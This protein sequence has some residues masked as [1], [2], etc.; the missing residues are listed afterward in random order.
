MV[1]K[2]NLGDNFINPLAL[3]HSAKVYSLDLEHDNH[4]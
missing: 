3:V 1:P 4:V 2:P